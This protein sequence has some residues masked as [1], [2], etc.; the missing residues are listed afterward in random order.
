MKLGYRDRIILLIMCVIIIFGI[1]IFVF[2]KPK[3]EKLSANQT[4]LETAENE[5][6]LQMLEFDKIP[7]KQGQIEKKFEEASKIAED[8]T[9][10]MNAV[11]LDQFLQEQ[12]M[13]NE[14]FKA[15]GLRQKDSVTFSDEGSTT[16]A[17]YYY[18][19]NVV[20]YPLYEYADLDGSLA[21]AAKEKRLEADTLS[22][23]TNQSVGFGQSSFTITT[24]R[25]DMMN[26]L[27][28]I[29]DY[30]ADAS[31][32]TGK[33]AMLIQSVSLAEYDFNTRVE[34][35]ETT[36]EP[37]LDP[38]TGEP[39]GEFRTVQGEAAADGTKAGF[40]D[41]T[42]NYEVYYMQEP[43]KPDVGPEYKKEIWDTSEWRTYGGGSAQE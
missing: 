27:N 26:L 43:T 31:K 25:D 17:Y 32:K 36:Q 9:E 37:I 21:E 1:G 29:H 35:G 8:F 24:Q 12:F 22:A 18:A 16:M 20:T 34:G 7:V 23:R 4:A 28:A 38:E 14:E 41:A 2:I 10:E 19:P 39:T 3:W 40:T 11:Q 6:N 30:A 15:N 5:W 33:D 42:I 13:N